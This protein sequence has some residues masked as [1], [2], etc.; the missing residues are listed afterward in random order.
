[1]GRRKPIQADRER[2]AAFSGLRG[3]EDTKRRSRKEGETM[4]IGIGS[5]LGIVLLI[6]L[7][8]WLF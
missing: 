2:R 6:L 5:V 4:Y 3:G 8:V 1:V 7:L